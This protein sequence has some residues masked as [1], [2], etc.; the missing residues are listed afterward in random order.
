MN[1][2]I[3]DF[4]TLDKLHGKKLVL[5]MYYALTAGIVV[6]MIVSFIYGIALLFTPEQVW[7]GLGKVLFSLPLAVLYFIILRVVCELI[8]ALF[9]KTGKGE[10]P[11]DFSL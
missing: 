6:N 10:D 9:D 11:T 1:F 8:T 5:L 3:K 2:S 7:I 4:F